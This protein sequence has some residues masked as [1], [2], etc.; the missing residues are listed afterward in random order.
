MNRTYINAGVNNAVVTVQRESFGTGR[1]LPVKIGENPFVV[2]RQ[3]PAGDI[4]IVPPQTKPQQPVVIA[5]TRTMEP[6][7]R[8]PPEPDRMQREGRENPRVAPPAPAAPSMRPDRPAASPP[9]NS[10]SIVR[11]PPVQQ[12][13]PPERFRRIRPEELK[14][15]RRL[16]KDRDASVFQPSP[17]ENLPVRKMREPKVIIRRPA[18]QAQPGVQPQ[19]SKKK[20][21]EEEKERRER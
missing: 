15:E 8:R 10:P 11:Q 5:P 18:P 21:H 6:A 7:R 9:A 13:L 16:I 3:R 17:P 1:H 2:T 14:N 19:Q 12:T 4:A 20:N